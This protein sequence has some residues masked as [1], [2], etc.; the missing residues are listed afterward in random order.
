MFSHVILQFMKPD[1]CHFFLH[2]FL[3]PLVFDLFL[4]ANEVTNCGN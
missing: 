2:L 1:L 3:P 4:L